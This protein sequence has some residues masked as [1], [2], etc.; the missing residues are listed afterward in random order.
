M[1]MQ[2]HTR[3]RFIGRL[4]RT[5]GSEFAIAFDFLFADLVGEHGLVLGQQFVDDFIGRFRAIN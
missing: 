1:M 5:R 3:G 2:M 4:R